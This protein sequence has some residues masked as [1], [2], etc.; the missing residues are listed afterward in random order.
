VPSGVAAAIFSPV[1]SSLCLW[2]GI[3]YSAVASRF[4]S[5]PCSPMGYALTANL[6]L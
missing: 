4:R 6:T 2:L 1:D 5:W 3:H